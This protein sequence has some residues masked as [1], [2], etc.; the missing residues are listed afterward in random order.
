VRLAISLKGPVF[1][2]SAPRPSLSSTMA[3]IPLQVV[4][5]NAASERRITPSWTI[6]QLKARLEPITGVPPLSQK[7]S[8]K[9]TG[10][11]AIAIEAADEE[12]TRLTSFPLT[13]Y[14]ELHVSP[15]LS[16]WT[17]QNPMFPALNDCC[18]GL[19]VSLKSFR[20]LRRG[21]TPVAPLCWD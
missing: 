15:R 14:A 13:P 3:D 1:Q 10:G 2:S 12:N 5:E 8:L 4:S 9:P 6:G 7:L 21:T 16:L 11:E 18:R 17:G 20:S 19:F